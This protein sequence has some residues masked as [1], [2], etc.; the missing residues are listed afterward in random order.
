MAEAEAMEDYC[1]DKTTTVFLLKMIF[2][3]LSST[4]FGFFLKQIPAEAMAETLWVKIF[5]IT[6]ILE[7][8]W[9]SSQAALN[10]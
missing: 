2:R 3:L 6:S 4:S 8:V 9:L 1:R 5:Y 7:I 10:F